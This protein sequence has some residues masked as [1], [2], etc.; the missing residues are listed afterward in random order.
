MSFFR[1]IVPAYN[2]RHIVMEGIDSIR[3][4]IFKDYDLIVLDDLST[5]GT[6]EYLQEMNLQT[7]ILPSTKRFNGGIR[8]LGMEYSRDSVYTLFLDSDDK[9]TSDSCFQEL[10][11]FII[12]H[13]LPDMVRLP[14]R[15]K[16]G[17]Y[18]CD[19]LL[20]DEDETIESVTHSKRVA[21][22]TKCVK[23]DLMENFPEN[24][25]MEDVAQHLAQCDVVETVAKYP[26]CFV[27]WNINQYSTSHNNSPKWQ[28]S[29]WRFVADLMDLKLT[30]P[31]TMERRDYKVAKAKENLYNGIITQ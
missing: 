25:L 24:T 15:R 17:S 19:M 16:E 31:Y 2:T 21:C 28:S 3:S 11:D 8:N 29:A 4:Q 20:D 1:V 22:W 10:H 23:T 7:L 6:R 9:F 18:I 13:D 30:K 26:K 14:Y 5:D 27:E 12:E